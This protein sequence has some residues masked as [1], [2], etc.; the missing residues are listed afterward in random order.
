MISDALRN[1]IK[2]SLEEIAYKR[3]ILFGS[4]ARDDYSIQ[5]DFDILIIIKNVTSK[6]KKINLS[7]LIRKRFAAKM[8]DADV[9]V[10][11]EKDIDYLKDKPGSVVRNAL[12]EGVT[13]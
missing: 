8:L 2:D 4:R 13:L 11:D 12:L 10:K 3:I 1:S 9:L 5:S 7:T 6:Q